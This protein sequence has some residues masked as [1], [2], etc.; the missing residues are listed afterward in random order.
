MSWLSIVLTVAAEDAEALGDAFIELGALS[1]SVEDADVGTDAEQPL[2]GEPGTSPERAAWSRSL[3]RVLVPAETD[4]PTLVMAAL[5]D[6]GI[7]A[8]PPYRV[9]ALADAD[10]VRLTQ[11]QFE[12]IRVSDRLWVVPTW[13]APPD[14]GAINLVLDPGVAFGTGAHATTR[15]CLRWLEA[16]VHGGERVLDYGC[17]SGILAIAA[18]KL[19]AAAATGIDIDAAAVDQARENARANGVAAVFLP[20][21]APLALAADLVVANILAN[22]LKL[23]APVL[24]RH[25]RRGGGLALA[26]LLAEQA[27]DVAASY[28][29]AFALEVAAIEESWA[30]LAGTR[31]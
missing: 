24:T 22:P 17:G 20:A 15:L 8:A 2:F 31:R 18:M 27:Q 9:E 25:T 5:R 26:G 1:I 29:D 13:H 7:D 3:V 6:A 10:W 16:N 12:P 21:A 4:A 30:L 11:A 19:G 23:L 28:R 14:P